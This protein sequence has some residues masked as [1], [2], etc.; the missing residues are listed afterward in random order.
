MRDLLGY[1][2]WLGALL[3]AGS[4]GAGAGTASD[5]AAPAAGAISLDA[6][7]E[8]LNRLEQENKDLRQE[9]DEHKQQLRQILPA[10][11]PAAGKEAEE[12]RDAAPDEA[13]VRRMIGSYL[14]EQDDRRRKAEEQQKKAAA[15]RG[16]EVGSDVSM[17]ASWKDGFNAATPNGDFRIHL[18]GRIQADAG[19]FSP[20][21][22]LKNA[23]PDRWQDGADFRRIRFRTDG[24]AYETM[25]WV[26]EMEFSQGINGLTTHPFP[27][28]AFVDFKAVPFLG[29][30]AVGHYKEPFS[31]EDYGTPDSFGVFMER[32]SP[33]SAFTPDRNLGIMWHDA[34]ADDQLAIAT[35]I[36]RSNSDA[37]SGNVFDY[38]DGEYAYT[39]RVAWMP[40]YEA[41]GRCWTLFGLAYSHRCLDPDDPGIPAVVP[42][43]GSQLTNPSRGRF[44]ARVP[45]RI[46]T[47]TIIDATN[48]V[49]DSVDLYNV[50]AAL[51]LGSLL[52]QGE[53]YFTQVN[54]ARRGAL[55]A[56]VPRLTNPSFDGFYVQASYFLTG[57]YHPLDRKW[58]RLARVRPNED[59]FFVRRG[60]PGHYQGYASGRG[61]W[62]IAARYGYVGLNSPALGAFPAIPGVPNS[63]AAGVTTAGVEHDI[64]LSLSVFMNANTRL[65]MNYARAFRGVNI[66][67]GRGF[68]DMLGVRLW[69]DF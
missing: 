7:L 64:T 17:K 37:R 62:E 33:D 48:L 14:Q 38:G 31:L 54:N 10:S 42:G 34:Y 52:L 35:G 68:V 53:Y 58:G 18:G 16:Y 63:G 3:L 44:A 6:V 30:I 69:W 45:L 8:R 39:S 22:A 41:N 5:A 25:D 26:L 29:N 13:A 19:W 43:G 67:A 12:D 59:F 36:F 15:E 11:A 61:A 32:S 56:D 24:T 4:I 27:T 50:Q 28:D 23:F 20:D 46:N 21:T 65:Q 49:A 47:P 9:L 55:A 60:E 66:P 40:Y 2:R 1:R 57:E 51:N